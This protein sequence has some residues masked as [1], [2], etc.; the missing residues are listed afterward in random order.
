MADPRTEK[1]ILDEL[2]EVTRQM[3]EHGKLCD[4]LDEAAERA[5]KA[6][7]EAGAGWDVF[8]SKR[9]D[10]LNELDNAVRPNRRGPLG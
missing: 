9:R 7:E 2:L 5:Q 4:E 10:L 1:E 3:A 8:R 6:A